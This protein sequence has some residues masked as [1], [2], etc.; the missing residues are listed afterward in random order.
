M[1]KP[2]LD[3][4]DILK[5]AG[6]LGGLAIARAAFGEGSNTQAGPISEGDVAA[7]E[8]IAGVNYT[9]TE[10]AMVLE[11]LDDMLDRV[12]R[13]RSAIPL[14]NDDA[15]AL[16]FDPRLSGKNYF[17]PTGGVRLAAEKPGPLPHD[18]SIAFAPLHEQA[19]WIKNGQL[20]S[21]RLTD[22]YLQR[23]RELNGRLNAFITLM[24]AEAKQQAYDAD[25]EIRSGKYKGPLHGIPYALKDLID[26]A[27]VKTT[28]GAAPYKDRVPE[29]DAVVTKR[30]KDAGAVLIGKA[31]MGAL[32]YGDLWYGGITRNPWNTQEGA[33]GSSAGSAAA[34]AA[35]LCSFAIGTETLGSIVSPSARCGAVGLRPTF[36]RVPRTGA[37]ALC[38]SLD[39]IGPICR[40]VEDTALVLSALNGADAGDPCSYDWGFAYDGSTAA[41]GNI[42]IG[43]DPKWFAGEDATDLDRQ[44]LDTLKEMGF[45]LTEISLPDLPYPTLLS[46]VEVE[47]AAAFEGLT[48]SGRDDELIWQGRTAWPNTFR[49]ARFHSAI[50]YVQLDRFRRQVMEMMHTTFEGVDMI[51]CPNYAGHML[52]ITNYTGHPSL[53]LPLGLIKRPTF[54]LTGASDKKMGLERPAPYGFTLWGNMFREDQLIGVGRLLERAAN[55]AAKRPEI[56]PI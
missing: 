31:S 38:W 37:M 16:T 41:A 14:E 52:V 5:G 55:F 20:T 30:L 50:E 39:K 22:I 24:E 54:P 8:K 11:E 13:R 2:R 53:T 15:P 56:D 21:S 9:A 43:Y 49:A 12:R 4:R 40:A 46:T 34:T 10:R 17:Q 47:A 25:V 3:R 27:G 6:L 44:V 29:G 18:Q 26:T 23:I 32:A 7:A 1:P 45:T 36:G 33:S 28:W 35:G 42:R 19:Y 51:A 48:L